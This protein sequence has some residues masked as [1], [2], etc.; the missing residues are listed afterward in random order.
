MPSPEEAN[1]PRYSIAFFAQPNKNS[2]VQGP[3][4]KY[5]PIG[6]GDYVCQVIGR[7]CNLIFRKCVGKLHIASFFL[8]ARHS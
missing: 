4:G 3:Q 5:P 6:A 2:I 7:I 8:D 1:K